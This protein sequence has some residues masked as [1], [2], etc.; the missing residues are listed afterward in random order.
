M[1]QVILYRTLFSLR[2]C[3]PRGDEL[4]VDLA[5]VVT[6]VRVRPFQPIFWRRTLSVAAMLSL[7]TSLKRLI[8]T[9]VGAAE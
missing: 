3:N 1:R 8:T 2:I 9:D 4:G 5:L 6:E 7:K